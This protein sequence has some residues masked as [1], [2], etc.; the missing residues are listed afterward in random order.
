MENEEVMKEYRSE[1][2]KTKAE[3]MVVSHLAKLFKS[4]AA[5]AEYD[6][7]DADFV[8]HGHHHLVVMASELFLNGHE[9]R[10][11]AL[12]R[13]VGETIAANKFK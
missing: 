9:G 4:M 1:L 13:I 2:A 3:E 6:Q 7:L 10:P 8:N 12:Q 5:T 11:D